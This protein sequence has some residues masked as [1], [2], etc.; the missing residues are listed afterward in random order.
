MGGVSRT[1]RRRSIAGDQ[2]Q[3]NHSDRRIPTRT[4]HRRF[5]GEI[6]VQLVRSIV[7][8]SLFDL[9]KPLNIQELCAERQNRLRKGEKLAMKSENTH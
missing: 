7:E 9:R 6:E 1:E 4:I 3:R 2:K 5:A 8:F